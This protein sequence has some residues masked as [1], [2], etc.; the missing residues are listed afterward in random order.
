[1]IKPKSFLGIVNGLRIFLAMVVMKL[2]GF[3]S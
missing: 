1:M 2:Q 3:L